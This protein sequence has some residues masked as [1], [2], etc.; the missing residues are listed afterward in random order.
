MQTSFITVTKTFLTELYKDKEFVI[1]FAS[2]D[3]WWILSEVI[4]P[5][6]GVRAGGG[7][8]LVHGKTK[9]GRHQRQSTGWQ[10]TVW[11]RQGTS[12]KALGGQGKARQAM[13]LVA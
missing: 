1:Q 6:L 7:R 11:A 3:S 12:G 13:H 9:Q 4:P 2:L 8:V 5:E 10:G